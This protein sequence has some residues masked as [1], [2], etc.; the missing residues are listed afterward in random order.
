MF[1]SCFF[2]PYM[3]NTITAFPTSY[4]CLSAFLL[5]T[6]KKTRTCSRSHYGIAGF[7]AEA[8][9]LGDIRAH[10]L[11][12]VSSSPKT[13]VYTYETCLP[14]LSIKIDKLVTKLTH[15][16][17]DEPAKGPSSRRS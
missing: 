10:C 8:T 16:L 12:V 14:K 6:G 15:L 9:A 4:T 5:N 3:I 11:R 13:D 7:R 2:F 17:H 1:F